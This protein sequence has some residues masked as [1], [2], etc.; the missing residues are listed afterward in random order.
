M[1]KIIILAAGCVLALCR[2]S[3]APRAAHEEPAP[4]GTLGS[5]VN[6]AVTD[7][8]THTALA[9]LNGHVA[10]NISSGSKELDS[11][12]AGALRSA[13]PNFASEADSV[14]RE[15][16]YQMTVKVYR[17]NDDA[18][19]LVRVFDF[20][21]RRVV[22]RTITVP[23][24]AA[25][26]LATLQYKTAVI[27]Q[28][29]FDAYLDAAFGG[30][31]AVVAEAKLKPLQPPRNILTLKGHSGYVMSAA[32]SPDGRRIVSSSTDKTVKI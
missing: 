2:C 1:K 16:L 27:A 10:I 4:S 9:Q 13:F 18:A 22:E 29:E 24:I 11:Q 5:I 31:G 19:V 6:A 8:Q 30:A 23:R 15:D 3:T 7:L 26:V 12:F 14:N 32:Y 21:D 17:E 25:A 20:E 28:N